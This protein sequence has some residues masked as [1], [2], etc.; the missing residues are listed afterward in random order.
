[1][2]EPAG[3]PAA[4]ARSLAVL[5]IDGVLADVR[6]RLHHLATRPKDWTGFFTAAADDPLLPGGAQLAH[7]L[8]AE[9]EVLYLTGRP[10]R[11]RELTGR[12]LADQQLPPGRLLMRPDGDH[13][14][15]RLFKR[16]RLRTLANE[17]TIASV[18][19]DDP[20]VVEL[21]RA[22]GIP[23]R[24][25]DELPYAEPLARAQERDGRT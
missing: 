11:I 20:Q 8:A 1:V 17:R 13:R 9:H 7:Q 18:V 2:G 12:W 25:A 16:E 24:L 23:V 6:H 21:L 10:E 5:D 4:P 14:P 22:A 3:P 19:D 15:A